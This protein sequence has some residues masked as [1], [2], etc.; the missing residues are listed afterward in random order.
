M[1]TVTQ[2]KQKIQ[3]QIAPGND[4]EFLRLLQEADDRLLEFGRWRWTRNKIKLTVV[5]G[6]MALD[7]DAPPAISSDSTT[8]AELRYVTLAPNYVSLVAAQLADGGSDIKDEEF[9]FAQGGVG[10]VKL[11]DGNVSLIDNG[12]VD[13][14]AGMTTETRRCYK[15]AGDIEVGTTI[16]GLAHYAP[17]KLYDP[18]SSD[19][20]TGSTD[21]PRCQDLAA[22]KLVMLAIKNEE[23]HNVPLSAQY[24]TAALRGLDEKNDALRGGAR[25]VANF[26]PNGPN[27]RR[28]STFY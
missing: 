11:L 14:T 22:L 24:M 17:A 10:N 19:A 3:P 6:F 13:V 16:T 28:T 5:D 15:V 18:D 1:L 21:V 26:R 27:I 4:V 12:Y 23:Q 9:E 7:V 2:L 25:Q 8:G 20:D